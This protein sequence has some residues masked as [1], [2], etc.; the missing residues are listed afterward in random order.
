[1]T[2]QGEFSI[3]TLDLGEVLLAEPLVL[4]DFVEYLLV[5]FAEPVT[6]V[7]RLTVNLE[8]LSESDAE[9]VVS[10]EVA[11]I[12]D[13]EFT[14]PGRSSFTDALLVQ[15]VRH[16]V[17]VGGAWRTT[18]SFQRRDTRLFLILDD[19]VQGKM[20]DENILAF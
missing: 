20:D 15:G 9:G 18:L 5:Q 10:F 1:V 8:R 2:S 13:V 6:R 4:E 17:T 12:C 11:D 16:D 3:R 19:A 7:D 14:P